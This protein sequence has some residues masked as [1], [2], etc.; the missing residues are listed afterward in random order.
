MAKPQISAAFVA[1]GF[2]GKR[3]CAFLADG[4]KCNG[5]QRMSWTLRQKRLRSSPGFHKDR[6]GYL[7]CCNAEV[8]ASPKLSSLTWAVGQS[9]EYKVVDAVKEAVARAS[10][11]IAREGVDV[12]LAIIFIKS[13]NE[14][15]P[16]DEIRRVLPVLKKTLA[17]RRVLKEDT[18]IFGCTT[19]SYIDEEDDPSVNVAL[20]S[21][22]AASVIQ[23]FAL[24]EESSFDI[25]WKQKQWHELVGVAP[26]QADQGQPGKS[27]DSNTGG[28]LQ[29][30][31]L[32]HP[33]FEKTRD[34]LA[35]LDFA[36]PGVRKFGAV[37]GRA[38]PLNT[39]Y[40]F[41][42]NGLKTNGVVG[43]AFSSQDLQVDVTVAQ[44]ARGVGPMMEVTEVREGN[45]IC[46][47]REI[48]T[49]TRV[50]A[51]PMMLLDMWAQTDVITQEDRAYASRYLLF[52]IEVQKV[53]DIAVSST[54]KDK[55]E[56]EEKV[57]KMEKDVD[58]IVRK[59]VAFNEATKSLIVEGDVRLGSRVQFQIRDEE[60]ARSE[61]T[62]L[63][64]KLSLEST[65]KALEGMSMMGSLLLV[66]T[67]RGANLYGKVTPDLDRVLFRERFPA[68]LAMLCSDKQ[69][70]P[71]P[72]GGLLGTAGNTFA[73]SASALYVSFYGRTGPMHPPTEQEQF[74]ERKPEST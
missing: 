13:R 57:S 36:Y 1:P 14:N 67:E 48:G 59:V 34:L 71:L 44:G 28:K 33:D 74:S 40:L 5:L 60:A 32:Q 65:S 54:L 46:K 25:D 70:G 41:D 24:S 17:M 15:T 50:E 42:S 12:D 45:E 64:N 53:V 66:D 16:D 35:G 4:S 2:C 29:L 37:A 43:L 23:P 72:S 31:L 39:A 49:P 21:F 47:V 9:T 8:N 69:L 73:L 61:L 7:I 62:F 55:K 3:N 11:T 56:K 10:A 58:M 26:S 52:G 27:G 19:A 30:F 51:A 68:P 18:I 22:P 20:A 38:H 6:P 63:F